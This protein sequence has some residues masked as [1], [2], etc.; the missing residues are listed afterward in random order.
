MDNL[1]VLLVDLQLVREVSCCAHQSLVLLLELTQQS[2]EGIKGIHVDIL[3]PIW[4]FF[5]LGTFTTGARYW[6][7]G[8]GK[9]ER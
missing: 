3:C 6:R 9:R 8:G 7:E 1:D 4:F 5:W 2:L